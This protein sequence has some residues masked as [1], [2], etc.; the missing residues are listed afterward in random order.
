M[1]NF[2]N[3]LLAVILAPVISIVIG[4]VVYYGFIVLVFSH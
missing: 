4:I 3:T 2:I 1:I